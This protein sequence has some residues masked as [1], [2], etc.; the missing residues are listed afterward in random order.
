MGEW[1][2]GFSSKPWT[3]LPSATS[4]S[5]YPSCHHLRQLGEIWRVHRSWILLVSC[6]SMRNDFQHTRTNPSIHPSIHTT[7]WLCQNSYGK[8]PFLMG[9]LTISMAIF[10]SYVKLPEGIMTQVFM[11]Q[12]WQAMNCNCISQTPKRCQKMFP[13]CVFDDVFPWSFP[14]FVTFGIFFGTPTV[15]KFNIANY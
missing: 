1:C 8:S 2:M 4:I 6:R 7:L 3:W 14:G 13:G 15:W 9:K 10:N 11:S 5:G 12:Q